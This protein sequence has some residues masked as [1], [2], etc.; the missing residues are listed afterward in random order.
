MIKIQDIEVKSNKK[1]IIKFNDGTEKVFDVSP[2]I[3][4]DILTKEL[5]NPDYFKKVKIYENGRGIYWPNGFD[6]CPDYL[7]YHI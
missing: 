5:N 7:R 3:G 4:N 2:I 6:V 1:I